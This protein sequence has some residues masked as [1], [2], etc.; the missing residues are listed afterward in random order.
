MHQC[1]LA[2]ARH[3]AQNAGAEWNPFPARVSRHACFSLDF[4]LLRS[5][6]QQP[7]SNVI[8]AEILLNFAGNLGEPMV[9]ARGDVEAAR[10]RAIQLAHGRSD[11]GRG[12]VRPYPR[13]RRPAGADHPGPAERQ[14]AGCGSASRVAPPRS[15]TRA[16]PMCGS[17]RRLDV[18]ASLTT[19]ISINRS[20]SG[21]INEKAFSSPNALVACSSNALRVLSLYTVG[22]VSRSSV[23]Q[24]NLLSGLCRRKGTMAATID[25]GA[26]L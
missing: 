3:P 11:A 18:C 2:R 22:N 26:H 24:I 25:I 1:P 16:R 19:C 13:T 10:D 7:D 15:A 12:P 5:S 6:V 23:A 9:F 21:T 4:H 20:M 17:R 8:E 14:P